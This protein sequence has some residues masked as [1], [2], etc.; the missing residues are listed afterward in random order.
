MASDELS[1]RRTTADDVDAIVELAGRALGWA[2]DERDRA[3]FRW[4][5][6]ENPFGASPGWA[7]HDGDRMVAFRTLLRWRFSQA[8]TPLEMVRAV[9]TAT[10]PEYQGR[11]LFRRLTTR[12]VEELTA[13][14]IDAV[15][16]TPNDQ[17][18]PGYLKMGWSA[19]GRPTLMVQPAS[20]S[21]MARMAR[22]RVAAAKWSTPVPV[23]EP[24]PDV[25]DALADRRPDARTGWSTPRSREY[26][27]WRYGFEPL[28][29]R[30]IEVRGGHAVFRVRERGPLREVALV[31]WLSP[32]RDPG[33]VRR[34]VRAAGD[35]AVAIGPSFRHGFVP[36]P[37]QGPIVTW[38]PLARPSVPVLDDLRFSL[39]DIELF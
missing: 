1:V 28:H 6:L 21:S 13:A 2:A 36:L 9:D 3:F 7:A 17:S 15:F 30:A 8:G 29:Y 38:R 10:D 27:S 33:A 25:V 12:A 35:Y 39:G 4:K 5:H 37:R 19:L 26:L 24:V 32:E 18:R 16:N 22:A 20:P 11:G 14:G 31:E 23:G 34:L